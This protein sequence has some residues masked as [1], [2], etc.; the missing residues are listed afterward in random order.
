MVKWMAEGSRKPMD[1]V[2]LAQTHLLREQ[3]KIQKAE[4]AED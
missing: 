2:L 4:Y 3:M 1:E